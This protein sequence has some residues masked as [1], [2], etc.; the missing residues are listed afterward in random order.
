MLS[1]LSTES[2]SYAKLSLRQARRQLAR[3]IAEASNIISSQAL[4]FLTP[5]VMSHQLLPADS[6]AC[7]ESTPLPQYLQ[8]LEQQRR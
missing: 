4:M 1:A 5:A 3:N 6:H 2:I 8:A 7:T